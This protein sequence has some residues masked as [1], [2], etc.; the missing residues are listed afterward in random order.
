MYLRLFEISLIA[1]VFCALGEPE[2]IFAFY[3]R[4][5]DKL[6]WYIANPLGACHKC[7][8]GEVCFWGY[9]ILYFHQYDFIN[10]L[11]FA[12]AGIFLSVIYNKLW[13][14]CD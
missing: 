3:Q 9:I 5:L 2:N 14:I 4:W 10:H 7:F 8:T 12:Y 11:F 6:P 13:Q 1:Y